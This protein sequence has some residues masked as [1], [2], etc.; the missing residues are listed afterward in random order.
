MYWPAKTA[1]V[2][3]RATSCSSITSA[4]GAPACTR[5]GRIFTGMSR[6]LLASRHS[7]TRLDSAARSKTGRSPWPLHH[8]SAP[9][10]VEAASTCPD[11]TRPCRRHRAVAAAVRQVDASLQRGAQQGVAGLDVELMSAGLYGDAMGHD[12]RRSVG[13]LRGCNDCSSLAAATS[14]SAPSHAGQAL[15]RVCRGSLRMRAI[16]N[17]AMGEHA[18]AA[19]PTWTAATLRRLAGHRQPDPAFRAAAETGLQ[20]ARTRALLAALSTGKFYHAASSTS[21]RP[22][23]MECEGAWVS[24]ERPLHPQ[25]GAC[26]ARASMRKLA[27]AVSAAVAVF[28]IPILRAPGSAGD[29]LP[30]A[31]LE[32]R[33]AAAA[34]K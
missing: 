23:S 24:E 5:Q 17:C 7:M 12:W 25:T 19:S 3:W 8:R 32:A 30:L 18:A 22:A 4:P 21:A 31:R 11:T 13:C 15:P 28:V 27:C 29:R 6:P 10:R 33:P 1:G 20:D 26:A 34:G 16:E 9:L 14:R 2:R